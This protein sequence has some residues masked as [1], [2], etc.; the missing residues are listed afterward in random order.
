MQMS[1]AIS[2]QKSQYLPR[3]GSVF[4]FTST[5]ALC[6]IRIQLL[7]IYFKLKRD[8]RSRVLVSYNLFMCYLEAYH[9]NRDHVHLTPGISQLGPITV[10][11]IKW[12]RLG[13]K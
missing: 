12:L 5:G 4:F 2:A 7:S 8:A 10:N 1:Q 11:N 6:L 9:C 13:F 3:F